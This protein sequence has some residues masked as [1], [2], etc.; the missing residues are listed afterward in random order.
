MTENHRRRCSACGGPAPADYRA[1]RNVLT[2]EAVVA[3]KVQVR[4]CHRKGCPLYLKP[5]RAEEEGRWALPDH[6]FGLDVIALIGALRYHEH[7]SVPEIHAVLR[8]RGVSIS[9]RSVTNQLDRY[10]ELLALRMTDSRRLQQ[11]TRQQG[12]VVL[13]MD[14]L[15]PE[16]G[17]EVLWVVRD[18]LSGEVLAARSL[19]GSGEAELVPLLQEVHAALA[20][21]IAG[22]VSDGQRSI[23][24]A[25]ASALPGVPH[26]LC[27]FHYLREAARPLYE[28]DRHAKK[29]L[30]SHVRGVRVI[31]RAVEGRQDAQAQ[32]VRGYCAAVRSAL[33]DDRRP[34]LK[35][36]GLELHRRLRAIEASLRRG[37]KRGARAREM[38]R[39][40]LLLRRGLMQTA[41]M[42]PPLKAAFRWV[43]RVAEFLTNASGEK[44]C[45]VKRR[46][47]GLVGALEDAVRRTR[48]P[49]R[50]ALAHFLLE[51]R[52]YWLGLFHCYDVPGLPRTD[53]DLEHLFGSCRYHERRASGRRRGS[54]GLVVRGQVRVVA[55]VATRLAPTAGAELAPKDIIAWRNLR[56]S[57]RRRQHARILGRRF[58][59]NPNAYLA[60]IEREL[61][62]ALP[63]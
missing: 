29:L 16:V 8:A 19:L 44:G 28:A 11:V 24:N 21:P 5:V 12:R 60:A 25:V 43:E 52:R 7:R 4:V 20:V 18:C 33:T 46:M 23:R 48:A 40:R 13:A 54:E 6:E 37:R 17:H 56:A 34:P 14:G 62:R 50:A 45:H 63:A 57:L 35:P 55:A 26:Q 31:E 58:R 27:H 59:A 49:H 22:V 38:N 2:L 41:R 15:Q 39:L 61:R 3:L 30:K 32:A 1:R 53:N 36:S 51:T 9:E 10:D 47:A 42:W